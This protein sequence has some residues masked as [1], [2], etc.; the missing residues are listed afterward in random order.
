MCV[1]HSRLVI[2]SALGYKIISSYS[3]CV[4]VCVYVCECVT[5]CL[6]FMYVRIIFCVL[7]TGEERK[8]DKEEKEEAVKVCLRCTYFVHTLYKC[9]I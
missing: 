7:K 1:S 4:C 2:I 3:V 9:I 5:M 8:D 6:C